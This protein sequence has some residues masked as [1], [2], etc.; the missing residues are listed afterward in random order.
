M[1]G[2]QPREMPCT[3]AK[4]VGEIIDSTGIKSALLDQ[5]QGSFNGC[6][7]SLPCGAKWGCLRTTT[8]ARTITCTLC[9][10]SSWVIADIFRQ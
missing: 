10:S 4:S 8:Q 9:R 3:H 5:S 1:L 6:F 2:K 7:G